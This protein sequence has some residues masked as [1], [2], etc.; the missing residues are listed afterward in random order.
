MK[1]FIWI[2]VICL[3]LIGIWIGFGLIKNFGFI[4]S[5]SFF[6]ILQVELILQLVKFK[7]KVKV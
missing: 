5:Y 7:V 2:L 3:H 4:E 6:N 1:I